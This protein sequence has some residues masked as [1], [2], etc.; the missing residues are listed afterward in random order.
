MKKR[1]VGFFLRLLLV[2][3]GVMIFGGTAKA[4]SPPPVISSVEISAGTY[5][6][7][8]DIIATINTDGTG[9]KATNAGIKIN[10]VSVGSTLNDNGDNT[11]TV[12]YAV[13]EGDADVTSGTPTISVVLKNGTTPCAAY[14]T[15]TVTDGTEVLIDANSPADPV[16]TSNTD[17][18]DD[19]NKSTTKAPAKKQGK[20]K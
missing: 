19:T 14:T 2:A 10:G 5:G 4:V 7:D 20:N 13:S 18:I 11:Y 9:Y 6:V 8:N 12:D 16:I 3:A 17:P 15:L 1:E